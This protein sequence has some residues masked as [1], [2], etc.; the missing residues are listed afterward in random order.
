M[1]LIKPITWQ[2]D[3]KVG[4]EKCGKKQKKRKKG[5]VPGRTSTSQGLPEIC[6]PI[7]LI[8]KIHNPLT[9]GDTKI[10]YCPCSPRFTRH[11]C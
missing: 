6:V 4:P 3:P 8:V 7:I 10:A 11:S 5:E 1:A 2:F 9:V